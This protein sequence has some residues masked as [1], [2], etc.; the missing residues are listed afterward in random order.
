MNITITVRNT[1]VDRGIKDYIRKRVSK[2]ERLY[3]RI[4]VCEVI[5]AE[6]KERKNIEIIL[7]LKRN[8]IVAKESSTDIYTSIDNAAE[9]IKKQLRRLK[10]RIQSKRRKV[11]LDKMAW[12]V[13]KLKRSE[14]ISIPE[15]SGQIIRTDYFANK[16][17]LPHEA[18][19]EIELT[20]KQ[21]LMFK[22]ADTGE[23]NVVYKRNDGNFGVIEPGF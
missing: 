9:T 2:M 22:N 18:K 4:G 15:E 3:K 1:E 23:S 11:I 13:S 21:F 5:V 14:E 7:H 8:K 17:M 10:G 12:P 20:E 16:P 6:E 19:I